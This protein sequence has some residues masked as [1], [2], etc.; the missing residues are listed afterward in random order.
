MNTT[1][2]PVTVSPVVARADDIPGPA[3]GRW[4]YDDYAKIP[5]DGCRYEVV[6]GVL[7]R[8]TAP[9]EG[10][11]ASDIRIGHY[12]FEHVELKG[13]GRVYVAPFDVELAPDT[14]VQP[15][16]IV[17]LKRN[18]SIIHPSHIIGAPDL[19]VEIASPS[20]ATHDRRTKL[21]AYARAGV[22][23]YWIAD[24]E[25]R[26]VELLFFSAASSDY[27]SQGVFR[28]EA[29]LR[30]RVVPNLPVAVDRFFA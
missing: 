22:S 23:E 15:D 9:S 11:Q 3:Q 6:E 19:V 17:V 29:T 12:L 20:T 25:A 4:T 26:T 24:A 7:Y 27:E 10:H 28:D 5:D 18:E 13:L 21:E 1:S 8:M 30:S 14:V 16:V 2:V